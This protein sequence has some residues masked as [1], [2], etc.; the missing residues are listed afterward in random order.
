L[1]V[2]G[3]FDIICSDRLLEKGRLVGSTDASSAAAEFVQ[4]AVIASRAST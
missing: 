3:E 1:A 4:L 2:S